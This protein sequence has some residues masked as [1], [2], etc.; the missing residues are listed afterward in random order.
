[1][2]LFLLAG[3]NNPLIKLLG[4]SFSTFNLLHRWLGRLVFAEVVAHAIAH[5]VG[6]VSTSGLSLNAAIQAALGVRFIFYGFLVRQSS[7]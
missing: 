1:M 3:R 6:W 4:I 7:F 2:L 5:L